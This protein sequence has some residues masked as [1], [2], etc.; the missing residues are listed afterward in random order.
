MEHLL[1]YETPFYLFTRLKKHYRFIQESSLRH[2]LCCQY[3]LDKGG[4]KFITIISFLSRGN[5]VTKSVD[6]LPQG[7]SSNI[8]CSFSYKQTMLEFHKREIQT[9]KEEHTD[10]FHI[11]HIKDPLRYFQS[12]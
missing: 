9:R 2:L 12:S 8:I 11:M 10:I 7:R 3:L 5:G 1:S 4:I 6:I